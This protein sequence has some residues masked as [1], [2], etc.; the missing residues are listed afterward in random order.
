ME[1][2]LIIGIICFLWLAILSLL[3]YRLSRHYSRLTSATSAYNLKEVL[4]KLLKDRQQSR[5]GIEKLSKQLNQLSDQTRYHLTR[6]GIIRFNPFSDTGGSQ[7]FTVSVLDELNN[8]LVMTSLFARTG[9]RWYVKEVVDG[10]G[11]DLELTK[12]E[13]QAIE[14]ARRIKRD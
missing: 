4:E 12:E 9:N 5:E 7:S 14:K 11:K 1:Y 8:G 2:N 3:F 10:I 13:R 6:I